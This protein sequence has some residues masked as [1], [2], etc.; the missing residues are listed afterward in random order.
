MMILK[1]LAKNF[2]E[3]Y[4]K[5]HISQKWQFLNTSLKLLTV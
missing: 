2:M 1:Y 4:S 5:R 3:N